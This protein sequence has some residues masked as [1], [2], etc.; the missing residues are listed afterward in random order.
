MDCALE[1][2]RT[3]EGQLSAREIRILSMLSVA[4]QE[5]A[6]AIAQKQQVRQG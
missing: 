6:D 4:R 2:F 3:N 5:L 1:L